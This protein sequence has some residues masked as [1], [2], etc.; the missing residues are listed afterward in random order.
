LTV[1]SNAN[2]SPATV[3]LTG[4]GISA[5]TNLALAPP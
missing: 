3:S 1:T 4:S 2:N 5:T